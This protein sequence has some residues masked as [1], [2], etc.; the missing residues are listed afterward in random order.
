[1]I[2]LWLTTGSNLSIPNPYWKIFL[3]VKD[4]IGDNKILA[5]TFLNICLGQQQQNSL[6]ADLLLDTAYGGLDIRQVG[7]VAAQ[8]GLSKLGILILEK[9]YMT[10]EAK[11]QKKFVVK[12]EAKRSKLSEDSRYFYNIPFFLL[13]YLVRSFV[14]LF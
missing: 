3:M 8:H 2:S 13:C 1:M 12:Q 7:R 11:E 14:C 6:A 5:E 10:L 9:F 4:G